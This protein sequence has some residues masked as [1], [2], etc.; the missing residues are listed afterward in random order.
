[1][2]LQLQQHHCCLAAATHIYTADHKFHD[3]LC[4]VQNAMHTGLAE[5]LRFLR[6][7]GS[8]FSLS[9]SASIAT[10]L[11]DDE[12]FDSFRFCSAASF[13]F[14]LRFSA[15]LLFKVACPLAFAFTGCAFS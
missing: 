3:T 4:I 10:E 13:S 14:C 7:D 8:A 12:L 6:R 2:T 9:A 1:M 15:S 11:L 5:V